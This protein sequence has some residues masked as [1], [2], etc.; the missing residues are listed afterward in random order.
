MREFKDKLTWDK[1][2][3]N[4][5]LTVKLWNEMEDYICKWN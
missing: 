1:V 2:I 5:V 4:N 3:C